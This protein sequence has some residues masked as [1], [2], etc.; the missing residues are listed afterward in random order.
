MTVFYEF[1]T[2]LI[3][4]LVFS[5][6]IQTVSGSGLFDDDVTTTPPK[7]TTTE[8]NSAN[9]LSLSWLAITLSALIAVG[10]LNTHVKGI[11]L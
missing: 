10:I 11:K 1:G 3:T 4:V 5:T 6:I 2:I 8:M 9:S 7:K